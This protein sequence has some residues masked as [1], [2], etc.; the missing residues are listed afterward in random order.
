MNLLEK[1]K[2]IFISKPCIGHKWILYPSPIYYQAYYSTWRCIICHQDGV[3]SNKHQNI[4][5][6]KDIL[7]FNHIWNN[8]KQLLAHE[9]IK[10][11]VCNM[12]GYY[13]YREKWNTNGI[14]I[15]PKYLISCNQKIIENIL[16]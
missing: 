11:T 7:K 2:N 8:P 3:S 16:K 12:D 13:F 14:N 5:S 9:N 15:F 10:C 1:I 6:I 4:I